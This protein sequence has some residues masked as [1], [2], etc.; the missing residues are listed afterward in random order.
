MSVDAASVFFATTAATAALGAFVAALAY[1]GYRRNDSETMR[2][3]AVGIVCLTVLPFL[4]IY[5][6][7]PLASLSDASA[8]LGVLLAFIAGLLA[9]VH[10]LD[11]A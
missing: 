7:A 3:L 4:V 11:R 10:A 2:S 9:V 1:R 8:L 5:V 6:G